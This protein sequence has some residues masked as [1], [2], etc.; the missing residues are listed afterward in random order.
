MSLFTSSIGLHHKRQDNGVCLTGSTGR[1]TKTIQS[2]K[3]IPGSCYASTPMILHDDR[4]FR[5]CIRQEGT[6]NTCGR[7][8]CLRWE[9]PLGF[10]ISCFGT[11]FL[12]DDVNLFFCSRNEAGKICITTTFCCLGMSKKTTSAEV[13]FST[14]KTIFAYR[15]KYLRKVRYWRLCLACTASAFFESKQ[16]LHKLHCHALEFNSLEMGTSTMF[17]V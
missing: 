17:M 13:T 9:P 8:K 14:R 11:L 12:F 6:C 2:F 10:Q 7:K 16:E 5:A 3:C 1:A 15:K 4:P